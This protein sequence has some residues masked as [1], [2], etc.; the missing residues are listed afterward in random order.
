M[1]EMKIRAATYKVDCRHVSFQFFLF[2]QAAQWDFD[3]YGNRRKRR[4]WNIGW[5]DGE[6]AYLKEVDFKTG[7]LVREYKQP[8]GEIA[9]HIHPRVQGTVAGTRPGTRTEAELGYDGA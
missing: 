9:T 5:T 6:Y 1:L 4:L 7:Q 3:Q 2:F 8:L